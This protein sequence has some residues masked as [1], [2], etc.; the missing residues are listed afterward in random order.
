[1]LMLHVILG[2]VAYEIGL[3]VAKLPNNN[4]QMLKIV[5]NRSLRELRFFMAA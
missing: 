2:A 1:M 3:Y 4:E 5:V